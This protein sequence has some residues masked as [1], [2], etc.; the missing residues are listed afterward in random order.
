[1]AILTCTLM[2]SYGC[3]KEASSQ[4]PVE[5]PST[6]FL[7]TFGG[8]SFDYGRSVALTSDGGYIIGGYSG[9]FGIA[10]NADFYLIK[11]D[12]SGTLVW[13]KTF[14][15]G[16]GEY[17]YSV[18][19]TTDGG[20]IIAG[21]TYYYSA[22]DFDILLIKTDANGNQLWQKTFGG[23]NLDYAYSVQQ[24]GD[25]GFVIAG[26]TY[27]FGAGL[28][29]LYLVKIDAGGNLQW[30]KTIGGSQGDEGH[31]VQQT[32]D[33]GYII[34]GHTFSFSTVGQYVYLVKTDASGNVLWQKTY[35]GNDVNTGNSVRQT[36]DGGYIIGGFTTSFGAGSG[37]VYLIRTDA[38]GNQL[39]QKTFGGS[40][41]DYGNCV[42][43]TSDGGFVI[44]GKT[45]SFGAGLTDVY[46]VKT[47][48]SGNLLWQAMFGGSN[49]DDGY[50]VQQTSD[51][52]FIIAGTTGSF[53]AGS[54][55]VL[56]IKT[57]GNGIVGK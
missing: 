33:G 36:S 43:Q 9:S 8:T 46:L 15:G 26:Y 20:F 37:D 50:A 24:T 54:Y 29:D 32:S 45:S 27:S 16:N 10:G 41:Y 57:D 47:D 23:A 14:G 22:G 30:Q 40:N 56:L 18:H 51:G 38:S 11:T 6:T 2:S 48:A 17:G 25:G 44:T 49:E 53:G 3:K 13:Q 31:S 39:W 55:D 28:S 7:K 42:R 52:G 34:T 4:A 35:G 21:F 5:T 12:A 19:Q 1:M